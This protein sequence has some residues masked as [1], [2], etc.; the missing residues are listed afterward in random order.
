M[1][2]VNNDEIEKVRLIFS[3]IEFV[4]AV[5]GFRHEGLKDGEE[6]AGIAGHFALFANLFR[7]DA[8]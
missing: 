1:A 6:H 5:F 2:F 4:F 7:V 8:A 3:K